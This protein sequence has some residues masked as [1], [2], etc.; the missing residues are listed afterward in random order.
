LPLDHFTKHA[1]TRDRLRGECRACRTEESR[2]Y[3]RRKPEIAAAASK[4]W[5]EKNRAKATRA[6]W[7]AMVRKK[8]GLS[9]EE[10][11][12]IIARGCA[13]CG[14]AEGKMCLDHDHLSG[15]VR[16]ALCGHCNRGIGMFRD[17]PELLEKAA[18]Y[19]VLHGRAR[20]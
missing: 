14:A 6:T 8:Y 1:M 2:E 13:I 10:Y 5:R 20:A 15:R 19:L 17:D 16:D 7:R 11:N 3:R 12:E 9:L 4:R 18:S